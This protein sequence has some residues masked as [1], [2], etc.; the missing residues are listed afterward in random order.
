[1]TEGVCGFPQSLSACPHSALKWTI[2][3]YFQVLTYIVY[4]VG[5]ATL[6]AQRCSLSRASSMQFTSS[7]SVSAPN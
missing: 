6:N 3:T 1:M 2:T 7:Q 5:R 4:A